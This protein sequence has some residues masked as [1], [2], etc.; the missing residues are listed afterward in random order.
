VA[1]EELLA[2]WDG[3]FLASRFDAMTGVWMLVGVHSTALGP[4]FGGTRM[5][6]YATPEDG[7]R[8]VLRLSAAM[9]AK[10]AMAELPFGGGKAVLAV[11]TMPGGEQRALLLERYADLL[12]SLGGSYVTAADMNTGPADMDVIASR[13]PYVLGTTAERGGSGASAP[14][15][16][17]GVYHAIRAALG[18]V[19][20]SDDPDG[21]TVVIQGV[22]AVGA[23]LAER[24]AGDGAK[25]VVTDVAAERADALS[26]RLGA[27]SVPVGQEYDVACDVF[28]PCATGGVISRETIPRLR[29]RIVAGAANN[30][31]LEPADADRLAT[32]GILYAPDYIVNAGGVIHLAGY[33]RL[34]WSTG[35]MQE[36]LAAIG[37]TLREVFAEADRRGVTPAAAADAIARDRVAGARA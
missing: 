18:H 13:S 23:P 19:F 14:D 29:C 16:A 3:E 32:A 25:L 33:E 30:Q 10:N 1:F 9:T 27:T 21:R 31:L 2:D 35:Q 36:R 5:K 22:G 12:T 11:P 15:T 24:L 20:D 34:G 37:E 7:A 8:D 17:F 28:A 4:G 6:T 26:S